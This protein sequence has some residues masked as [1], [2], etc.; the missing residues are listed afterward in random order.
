MDRKQLAL[1]LHHSK[2]NCAQ[3]VACAFANVMGYD[4]QT[5]FKLAEGFGAGM[6]TFSTC[7]AVSAMAMVIGMKESDGELDAPATKA[8]C[9][10]L[11]KQATQM[12]EEKNQSTICRQIKGMDGGPVLRS[13]DGCIED[14]VEILDE[15]LLGLKEE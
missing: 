4:P 11:M 7:G 9:Y 15:L 1:Q 2:F 12:F 5:V 8:H 14:A 13:C 3:S 6:G 10:K